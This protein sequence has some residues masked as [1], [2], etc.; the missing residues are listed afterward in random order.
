MSV[1][2]QMP[3]GER[4]RRSWW[5]PWLPASTS[6]ARR[7]SP[8]SAR[9]GPGRSSPRNPPCPR[10]A[11]PAGFVRVVRHRRRGSQRLHLLHARPAH[12][13]R[14]QRR[15]AG[16]ARRAG[17]LPRPVLGSR[18]ATRSSS[19]STPATGSTCRSCPPS[20]T[21]S[22]SPTTG[23]S[24]SVTQ[25]GSGTTRT[26]SARSRCATRHRRRR[27]RYRL[28]SGRDRH[29]PDHIAVARGG[30]RSWTALKNHPGLLV[31]YDDAL[32]HRSRVFAVDA[33]GD[34]FT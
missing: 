34:V 15:A 26:P 5:T 28:P 9:R 33:T 20:P 23:R 6:S 13:G 3:P 17:S 30:D 7:G 12:R 25:R 16:A 2:T 29:Q 14:R 19:A 22:P 10:Q 21:S 31:G 32:V 1:S 8:P 4:S 24:R 11:V 27:R 18:A